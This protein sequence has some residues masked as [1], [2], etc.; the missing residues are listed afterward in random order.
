MVNKQGWR[1]SGEALEQDKGAW[2]KRSEWREI[3]DFSHL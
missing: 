2:E 3:F 1:V